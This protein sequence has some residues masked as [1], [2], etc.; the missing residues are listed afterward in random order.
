LTTLETLTG[1]ALLAAAAIT[2]AGEGAAITGTVTYRERVRLPTGS[3][4]E[5]TLEDVSRAR[6]GSWPDSQIEEDESPCSG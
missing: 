3:V 2:A 6:I 4:L 1:V 5:A